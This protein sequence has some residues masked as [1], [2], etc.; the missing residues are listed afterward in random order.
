MSIDPTK[1]ITSLDV[2]PTYSARQAVAFLPRSYSWLDQRLRQGQFHLPDG[3]T[4]R[5]TRT[6]GG[7]RRFSLAMVRD[8][9]VCSTNAGL[10]SLEEL[11]FTLRKLLVAAEQQSG[12]YKIPN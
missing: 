6:S 7:Y 10:F 9:A 2:E 11:K 1:A 4:V 12:N 5:P 3:R 8:I